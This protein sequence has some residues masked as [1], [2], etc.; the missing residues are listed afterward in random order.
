[1]HV[2]ER[3]DGWRV[4]DWAYD[5]RVPWELVEVNRRCGHNGRSMLTYDSELFGPQ[6]TRAEKRTSQTK[7]L[8]PLN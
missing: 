6:G 7:A 3:A 5:I 1:V 4:G 8:G 2:E